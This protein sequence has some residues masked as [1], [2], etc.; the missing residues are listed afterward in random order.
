MSIG[1]YAQSPS[2]YE[3][4]EW[5]AGTVTNYDVAAGQGIFSVCPTPKEIIIRT[6]A[7]ITVRFNAA[8]N[9]AVT[10]SANTT[11]DVPLQASNI[12]ITTTGSSNIKI[13]LLQ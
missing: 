11:F 2:K 8:T 3:S 9:S 13:L 5:T 6:D 4:A 1:Y 7:T 10:V 12:Y